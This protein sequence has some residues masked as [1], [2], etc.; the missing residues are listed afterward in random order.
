VTFVQTYMSK[1][2]LEFKYSTKDNRWERQKVRVKTVPFR[3]N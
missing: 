1:L 2:K 3:S